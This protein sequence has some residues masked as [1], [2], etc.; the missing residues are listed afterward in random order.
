[1]ER[2]KKVLGWIGVSLT[3]V[4]S[5][6]GAYWGAFENFHEGWY[7][8]SV[9]ENILMMVFQYLL[10]TIVFVAL[11]LIILKWKKS[12]SPSISSPVLSASVLLGRQFQ[13]GR[14]SG[15]HP[16]RGAGTDLLLR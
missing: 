3:V 11:A 1:M 15:R 10:F 14:Y 2:K 8:I 12:A 6:L 9:W 5:S 16:L 4:F 13:C 7:S